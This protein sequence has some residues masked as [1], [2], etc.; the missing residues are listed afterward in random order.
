MSFTNYLEGKVMDEVFGAT[1][2]SAP[3][4]LFVAL[5]SAYPD[6]AGSGAELSGNG[7]ARVSVANN[8]TNFPNYASDQKKNGAEIAF[9]QATGNW[10]EAVAVSIFD[11]S[12]G[13]NMLARGWLGSD[14]GKVFVAEADDETFNVPGHSLVVDDKVAVIAIPGGT[15][16]TGVSE[17]T[18]YFVKTV[19]GNVITLSATQGGATLAITTDGAGLIKKVVPKT[20]QTNDT[21][22]FAIDALVLSLD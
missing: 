16:P 7:Y 20:V 18:I 1:A 3:A 14:A 2:F 6:E 22:K 17:G 12:S 5:H 13:G 4:N 21:L 11:A 9:P 10:S 15:L 19:T 8:T